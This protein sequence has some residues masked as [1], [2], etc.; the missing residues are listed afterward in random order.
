[1]IKNLT[2]RGRHLT[3]IIDPHIKAT[4]SYYVHNDCTAKGY[5]TKNKDGNDYEGKTKLFKLFVEIGIL[6]IYLS[7]W[8][9]WSL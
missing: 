2:D 8:L 4:N 9:K 7:I 1:M 6:W 5:Y 3:I